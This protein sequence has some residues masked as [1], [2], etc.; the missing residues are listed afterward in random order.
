MK[1]CRQ[2]TSSYTLDYSPPE[3]QPEEK[4]TIK[5]TPKL[6]EIIEDLSN[7]SKPKDMEEAWKSMDE[8][9]DSTIDK[10]HNIPTPKEIAASNASVVKAMKRNV[11]M[12][13]SMH[14]NNN[15]SEV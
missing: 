14:G 5:Y 2:N 13:R 8:E 10:P 9:P 4:Y 3:K 15:N 12:F 7:S 6:P 1:T 11:E